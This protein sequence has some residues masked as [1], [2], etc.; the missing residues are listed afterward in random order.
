MFCD[1]C[2]KKNEDTAK[3]CVN[4]G[5]KLEKK[6]IFSFD[7]DEFKVD[8][9]D[10]EELKD[11][12]E[13]KIDFIK[14]KDDTIENNKEEIKEKKETTIFNDLNNTST[15]SDTS[16]DTNSNTNS[17]N[18][19]TFPFGKNNHTVDLIGVGNSKYAI[20]AVMFFLFIFLFVPSIFI[21][22]TNDRGFLTTFGLFD[23][24][25]TIVIWVMIFLIIKSIINTRKAR[26]T[27]STGRNTSALIIDKYASN[28]RQNYNY[29]NVY[30]IVFKYTINKIE[31]Q[32]SQRVLKN[33]YDNLNIGDVINIKT[34][35]TVGVY[36]ENNKVNLNK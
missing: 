6:D 11:F 19:N 14:E 3:F 17:Y 21:F 4:C 5:Y 13:E 23:I 12:R 36:N 7:K 35:S 1:N 28:T 10:Y 27:L 15:I 20:L 29:K 30:Y 9:S 2:G 31:H 34:T 24:I 25:W 26:M 16:T 18:R 33:T 8:L 22:I 32:T